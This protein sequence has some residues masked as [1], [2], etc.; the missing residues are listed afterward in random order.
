M[1]LRADDQEKS[2][3]RQFCYPG[4]HPLDLALSCQLRKAGCLAK[5][6][7]RKRCKTLLE[8]FFYK[9]LRD[10]DPV[11]AADS[12]EFH[13]PTIPKYGIDGKRIKRAERLAKVGAPGQDCTDTKRG[14]SPLPLPWATG[15]PHNG[16]MDC[17]SAG[18]MGRRPSDLDSTIHQSICPIRNGAA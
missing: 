13:T 16:V 15:A 7:Q 9:C 17:W 12:L 2:L 14:L 5:V 6:R 18:L 8:A 1:V 4:A 11:I 10:A 3:T